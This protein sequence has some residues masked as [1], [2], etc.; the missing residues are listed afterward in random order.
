MGK[1]ITTQDE[2][3][4]YALHYKGK[5]LG[6]FRWTQGGPDWLQG[7]RPPKKVYFKLGLARSGATY[8][9][10]E[11]LDDIEIVRY[12]PVEVVEKLNGKQLRIKKIKK[13]LKK[14]LRYEMTATCPSWRISYAERV[15]ELTQRLFEVES[16]V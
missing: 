8:L 5:L 3:V 10:T 9:P 16:E 12:A 15:R 1:S 6:S 11:A 13:D 4:I 7:W 14:Y 2:N